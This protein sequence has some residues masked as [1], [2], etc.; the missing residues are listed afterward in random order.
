[1]DWLKHFKEY[2]PIY[3]K[4]IIDLV[5]LRGSAE[6]WRKYLEYLT[7]WYNVRDQKYHTELAI[8][9]INEIKNIVSSKYT[10][11]GEI[12][13]E[14]VNN[15]STIIFN[16]RKK[17]REFLE[18]SKLY[19]L[20]IIFSELPHQYMLHEIAFI[21][22]WDKKYNIAFEIW[23]SDLMD[24]EYSDYIW[25]KV[26]KLN[27]D[28]SIFFELFKVYIENKLT[29]LAVN[30]LENRHDKMPYDKVFS[31]FKDDEVLREKYHKVFHDMFK[32]I[33]NVKNQTLINEQISK[34][35]VLTAKAELF[36]TESNGF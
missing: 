17:L 14:A 24:I 1:M 4:K 19:N 7:L 27:S 21:L 26:Y 15:D 35:E 36:T 12:D 32:R 28:D 10:F 31:I 5:R 30:L 11:E 29:D 8:S 3:S 16:L 25:Q 18:S 2:E 9:Y 20:N 34:Y 6:L 22:A 33:Q 13:V 23:V